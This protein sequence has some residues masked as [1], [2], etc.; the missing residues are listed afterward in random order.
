M[1][2]FKSAQLINE[3]LETEMNVT[4]MVKHVSTNNVNNRSGENYDERES[5]TDKNSYIQ[6]VTGQKK[7]SSLKKTK[8]PSDN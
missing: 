8:L 6:V 4:H 3:L 2:E 1:D 7:K 5:G